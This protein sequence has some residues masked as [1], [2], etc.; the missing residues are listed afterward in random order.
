MQ[1]FPV[2]LQQHRITLQQGAL[3]QHIAA[4]LK[5]HIAAGP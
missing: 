4:K 5:Q 1:P 2:M 3:K